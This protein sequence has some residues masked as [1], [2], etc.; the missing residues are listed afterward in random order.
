[1]PGMRDRNLRSGDLHEELGIFLLKTV[2]LVAPVPRQEDVGNDAFATLIRPEGSRRLIPDLSFLVQLKSASVTSVAY[3]TTDEMAWISALESPLFIGRVDLKQ[4]R[5]ELF[6]TLRLHQILLERGYDGIELLL[7]QASETST[8][9]GVRRAN[10][11]PPI[12]AWST[13]DVTEP[14]FLGKS[15]AVLRPHVDTLRRNRLLRGIQSQRVLR[16]E[17][18]QPP[19]DGGEIM[20]VSPEN[21]IADTLREMAP[22]ARRLMMDLF[23][24]MRAEDFLVMLTFFDLMRRR[25]VDPDPQGTISTMVGFM[26]GGPEISVEDAIRIR[27]AFQRPDCLDLS[28]LSVSD[29]AVAVIPETVTGLGLVNAPI[30]DACIPHL[31]RLT[32]LKRLNIAGTRITDDGLVALNCLSNLEWVCVNRTQVTGQGVERLKVIRP[33]IEVMIGAE[34]SSAPSTTG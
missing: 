29:E 8:T 27:C 25:G 10:I 16:W 1:M 23:P 9:P 14:D 22:H 26:A 13:A 5:I 3:T 12:H 21:D 33:A 4:A 32:G 15:Y 6:T 7:D 11:G 31:L 20:H 19:T 2:A 17:T 30:T 24:W 34:P 18:G 28:W